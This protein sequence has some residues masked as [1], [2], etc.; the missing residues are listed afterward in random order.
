MQG[1]TV[2]SNLQ[3]RKLKQ[4][5]AKVTQFVQLES[6]VQ[7]I[8]PQRLCSLLPKY[9]I[10][11]AV[12]RQGHVSPR[13]LGS[14]L[15]AC[16]ALWTSHGP[17]W[18][19]SGNLSPHEDPRH[20][21]SDWQTRHNWPISRTPTV[22]DDLEVDHLS[23]EEGMSEGNIEGLWHRNGSSLPKYSS[24]VFRVR[25]LT[26][27]KTLRTIWPVF[28][29]SQSLNCFSWRSLWVIQTETPA[30]QNE[31]CLKV[32]WSVKHYHYPPWLWWTTQLFT[33]S[34]L[35]TLLPSMSP[36]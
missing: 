6:Q 16:P 9:T 36:C 5:H 4:D 18:Q 27:W 23:T 7:A 17:P 35:Q 30:R 34:S 2:V 3:M 11:C 15:G 13:N 22:S 1:T 20:L 29:H 32:C 12:W 21:K 28:I 25:S 33:L 14:F 31:M 8:W 26:V 24:C 10:P 19:L